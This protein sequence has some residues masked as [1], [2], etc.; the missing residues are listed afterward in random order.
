M[1]RRPIRRA[2]GVKRVGHA[3]TLDPLASGLLLVGLGRATRLLEYLGAHA[4]TYRARLRL[5]E[6]RDTLLPKLLSGELAT[7]V[8]NGTL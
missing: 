3:G 4:K 7:G 6:V 2:S 1:L 5:G 8:L